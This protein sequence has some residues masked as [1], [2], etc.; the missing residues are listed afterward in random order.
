MKHPGPP[1]IMGILNVTPDS[2]S[3]GG[4]YMDAD[5]AVRHA[6]RMAAEGA[7]IIDI[8][9][10]STRPGAARLNAVQQIARV[11]PV[12]R[13][14]HQRLSGGIRISIDTTLAEVAEAALDAGAS[15][16]NDIS[17][18]RE[19]ATMFALAAA[20]NTPIILM[21]MQGTPATMQDHPVYH[22]V[23]EEINT[24]L[25]ARAGAAEAAGVSCNNIIIDP[26][27]GFGKLLEHNL[28][29]I[30]NLARFTEG[31]YPVL[32]GTSRKRFLR[33]LCAEDNP[34]DIVGA[35]CATTALGVLAGV[36]LFRVH[37]VRENRQAAE[38]VYRS[39]RS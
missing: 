3:D 14:L 33:T 17:A 1:R 31:A 36:S 2:F 37:D 32:M 18:G 6:L 38:V 12:I 23:V 8:G 39:L 35:T 28:E 22:N 29:L 7:D 34:G 30:K 11:L 5:A 10:E 9:G 25:L 24:F 4:R 20:R 19:D 15:I 26:G 27:F 21:H 16:I 13:A